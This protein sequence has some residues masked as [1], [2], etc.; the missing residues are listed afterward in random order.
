M[1]I[2]M[3]IAYI[4]LLLDYNIL[5]NYNIFIYYILSHHIDFVARVISFATGAVLPRVI[6]W[7]NVCSAESA[8]IDSYFFTQL[9]DRGGCFR[10][11]NFFDFVFFTCL[12]K[13]I[14]KSIFIPEIRVGNF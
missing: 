13:K 4:L 1:Y 8:T 11:K 3:S 9:K 7:S 10:E 14:S 12:V 5:I 2:S 6:R